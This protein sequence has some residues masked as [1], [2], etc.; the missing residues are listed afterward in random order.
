ML[1][2]PEVVAPMAVAAIA[3]SIAALTVAW[4]QW[5]SGRDP[6]ETADRRAKAAESSAQVCAQAAVASA[7][8]AEQSAQAAR[9]SAEAARDTAE[10][11]KRA[12][13]HATEFRLSLKSQPGENSALEVSVANLGS[14]PARELR[15]ASSFLV[16][17][18]MPADVPLKARVHNVALGPGVSFSLAHFLRV[19]PAEYLAISSGRKLLVASGHAQYSDVFGVERETRWCAVYDSN[20]KAFLAAAEGNAAT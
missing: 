2:S 9:A 17:D 13:V 20:V 18:E 5:R 3:V 10:L 6:V 14:T 7:R 15:V 1:L 11:A 19:S 16:C 12:W 8:S 4:W